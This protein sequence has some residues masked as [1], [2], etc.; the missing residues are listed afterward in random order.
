M[1]IQRF[2]DGEW[3]TIYVTKDIIGQ[4]SIFNDFN[5]NEINRKFIYRIVVTDEDGKMFFT[6][7]KYAFF[8]LKTFE[9]GFKIK[10][11]PNNGSFTI[12]IPSD[13]QTSYKIFDIYGKVVKY[14]HFVNGVVEID[15]LKP[16]HYS[17]ILFSSGFSK[18]KNIVVY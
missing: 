14:G 16:G 11:N 10:P 4:E 17:I 7:E 6:K 3:N 18:N 1:E 2:D 13:T 15:L 12:S 5:L 9:D 8:K